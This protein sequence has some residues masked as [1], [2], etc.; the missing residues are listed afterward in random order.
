MQYSLVRNGFDFA[1][2][3][4]VAELVKPQKIEEISDDFVTLTDHVS[5]FEF[6]S[7]QDLNIPE[8]RGPLELKGH[9]KYGQLHLYKGKGDPYL[10]LDVDDTSFVSNL[11]K[12]LN[13]PKTQLKALF[14]IKFFQV[15]N[16][17]ALKGK[18]SF[19]FQYRVAVRKGLFYMTPIK[20]DFLFYQEETEY[21]LSCNDYATPPDVDSFYSLITANTK[22]NYCSNVESLEIPDI[23]KTLLPF[24]VE[25][26][27][28]M[29]NHE[30]YNM[31]SAKQIKYPADPN[32]NEI[33]MIIDEIAPYWERVKSESGN[34]LWYNPASSAIC[35]RAT[36]LSYIKSINY[37]KSPA[38]GF[39]C[40]EMGLG[41]TLELTSVIKLNPRMSVSEKVKT[42][43]FDLT[44]KIKESKTTIIICPETIL[45]QWYEEITSTC[46]TLTVYKYRGIKLMEDTNP[47]I[48]PSEV[49][50]F[51]RT[52]DIVL[53]AYN[54][55]GKEVDRASFVPTERPKRGQTKRIDYSSP[56][57]LLEFYRLVIDEAQLASMHV[58]RVAHFCSILP[59]VHTWCVSGTIIRSNLQDLHSLLGCQRMYPLDRVSTNYWKQIPRYIFDRLFKKSCLRHTKEM[60]GAQVKLPK[61]TRIMLRSPFSTIE[62]DN[63][64]DLFNRFLDEVG[65]DSKGNPVAEGY[66]YDR[67]QALMRKWSSK[68]RMACCHA[69][70]SG[71]TVRRHMYSGTDPESTYKE[72]N[73]SQ[74]EFMIG[75]LG[76]VL[77]DLVNSIELETSTLFNNYIR[78]YI[79]IGK[80]TE[81][82][83][84][85]MESVD[86]F[87]LIID[88]INQKLKEYQDLVE[89]VKTNEKKKIWKL[90]IRN[91]LEYLHQAYFMLASAHYQHYS[92]MKPLPADF[93]NLI[94]TKEEDLSQEKE[95]F[96]PDTLNE[97]EHK[98]YLLETEYY[99]K[100]NEVLTTLL[101][102][103]LKKTEEMIQKLDSLYKKYKI[104]R[105][106]EIPII[107]SDVKED[108]YDLPL[109]AE[110]FNC[111]QKNLDDH[112][113]TMAIS[114]II[115]RAK[116]AITQLDEQAK[117]I[118]FWFKKLY[119][120]QKQSVVSS[121][122]DE[123]GEEYSK[124]LTLQE[125]SQSYIDQ[126][127]L[128]LDDR[129]K[130]INATEDLLVYSSGSS[131]MSKVFST[132]DAKT[133]L[134]IQLEKVRKYY[135]PQGTMNPR[136]SFHTAILELVGEVQ[137]FLPYT[138]KHSETEALI[139]LLKK[140][141]KSQMKNVKQMKSKVFELFND[142]FNSKV[143]YFKSLQIRSDA[144][145]NYFPDKL[146]SS[147]KYV[148]LM[149]LEGLKKE[150]GEFEAKIRMVNVR[151]TYLNTLS[152]ESQKPSGESDM[153]I[154]CRYKIK[155][156]MLT[157]CG[158]KYCRECMSEWMR[159]KKA[160]PLC[161]KP[162]KVNELYNFVYSEGG[163]KGEV[164]ESLNENKEEIV[165]KE[166]DKD[167]VDVEIG[168]DIADQRRLELLKN[169]RIFEKD[170]DFV[171][172]GLPNTEL[173]D[174]ISIPLK[175]SYG[176]KI[177]MIIRQIKYLKSKELGVQILIFSQWNTFLFIL[178]RAL[179]EEGVFFFSWNDRNNSYGGRRKKDT[180]SRLSQNILKFKKDPTYTCFLMNTI[181]QAAGVTLTNASHVFL[182]EPMVSLSLEL[183]AVNRIHRIGQKKETKVWSFI[184]EGTIEESIAYLGTKKRIQAAR[185]RTSQD[186]VDK[187]EEIDENVLEAKEL[188]K[189]NKTAANEGEV[190][191]D[192]DL[193]A[194]F[195]A[196]KA[197]T[198]IDNI[199]KK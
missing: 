88:K 197:A 116:E 178:G 132:G 85:P 102:D 1:L 31:D 79:R 127:Q 89:V 24:Q 189:V 92:P 34:Y 120:K 147:P 111:S 87:K 20:Y 140:E 57:M 198:I 37:N 188:T 65:L 16:L 141:M 167:D 47:E 52:F 160:C 33:S 129:E 150:L 130:A 154:I 156:G 112:S 63:Y 3:A 21:Q 94:E 50:G 139:T 113:T 64:Y 42:D 82:L 144:L 123:Q 91:L 23:N 172:Q 51:L 134:A 180:D 2:L 124:Y 184:I 26:V 117:I 36:I 4:R 168:I 72:Q 19:Q 22:K 83:R 55:L 145:V 173:R 32:D 86:I 12:L 80:I 136:Y 15:S 13:T 122:S 181:A 76:D 109:I 114:F 41:K 125:E 6:D 29:L 35:D 43:E 182:C 14:N 177:D 81:F 190:I 56:L 194:A 142:C 18:S 67:S 100:A 27:K 77:D 106:Y 30:G 48:T 149:E 49:A 105:F 10:K 68:L 199:Y 69:M 133:P 155:M 174:I 61:Q 66:D 25:S 193:W 17:R 101:D 5:T 71:D 183:Q 191:G 118:N 60:V 175:A 170:I 179:R 187:I 158:H 40:E 148:A 121:G 75:T 11:V 93:P 78:T 146:G 7:D 186:E 107:E 45:N 128:I 151:L 162:L 99:S 138:T 171:Y 74:N 161:N 38:K 185:D 165:V 169:R 62:S 28:W 159:T 44:R 192:E 143:A 84:K 53:V 70:L 153:C 137:T 95:K 8:I 131:K 97:E 98:H 115:T 166:D 73:H 195:F 135:I 9:V 152:A 46:D 196:S 110:C 164:V 126:L 54:V 96:D 59:R 58:S 157:P 103:P 39:L 119:D 104:Q 163:L 176:T 90:R 108:Y